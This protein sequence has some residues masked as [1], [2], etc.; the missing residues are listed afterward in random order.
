MIGRH[1]Y[2]ILER[3]GGKLVFSAFF[4]RGSHVL[5]LLSLY[6][7]KTTG[8]MFLYVSRNRELSTRRH[9]H[10]KKKEKIIRN[11]CTCCPSVFFRVIMC[12]KVIVVVK[13][14]W[15]GQI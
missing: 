11:K 7:N 4:F 9:C 2:L 15:E 13:G 12:V 8:A 3:V 14:D 5:L 10:T 6:D 1:L